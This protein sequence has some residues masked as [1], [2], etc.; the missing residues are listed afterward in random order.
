MA[1]KIDIEPLI[2]RMKEDIA[3]IK[4]WMASIDANSKC[5]GN[6]LGL[7]GTHDPENMSAEDFDHNIEIFLKMMANLAKAGL[8]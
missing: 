6:D 5:M 3:E 2:E 7:R 1:E 4:Q 8:N